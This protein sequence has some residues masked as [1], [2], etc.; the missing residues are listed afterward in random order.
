MHP[1]KG[2]KQSPEH[3]ARRVA[4]L[5]AN[6]TYEAAG[7]R[8]VALNKSRI[9]QPRS[10]EACKKQSASCKGLSTRWLAGRKLPE[11]HR[12]KLADFWAVNRE[13]HNH[14]VDGKGYERTGE[15]RAE[16]GRIEYRLWREAVF[17]RDDF[18]CQECGVRGCRLEADHIRPWVAFPELRY[19]QNNGRTL[20]RPCHLKAP[21]HG[22]R[23]RKMAA[24]VEN[25]SGAPCAQ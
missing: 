13:K 1:L 11:E 2:R 16:M 8:M 17:K 15:R 20:C 14:Y 18:T 19:D 12:R 21:T 6:A 25:S 22:S 10:E 5:Y 4:A 9:G 24:Q 23:A 7:K 3:I